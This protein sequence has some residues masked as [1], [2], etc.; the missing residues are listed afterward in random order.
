MISVS[1]T[2]SESSVKQNTFF[3][4]EIEQKH[5]KGI[6]TGL[7]VIK[8][9]N[10]R[11]RTLIGINDWER[12]KKQD[13]VINIKI[14]FDAEKSSETDKIEDT[15]N[16][17]LITKQI[18]EQVESRSYGLIE[19]MAQTIIDVVMEDPQVIWTKV[20]VDKPYALRFSDSVSVKLKA[21]RSNFP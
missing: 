21:H 3:C 16:Y 10:L 19:R 8:I 5:T 12:E 2:A 17:K 11:L 7:G 6:Q 9:T 14:G 20:K 4:E 18:I 15:V 13:V 1:H